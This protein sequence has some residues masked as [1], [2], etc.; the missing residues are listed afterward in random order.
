MTDT[1]AGTV[2]VLIKGGTVVDAGTAVEADVALAAGVVVGVGRLEGRVTADR[3]IDARGKIVMPGLVDG[4]FHCAG[5]SASP[6]A[7]DMYRGT[8]SAVCGGFTTVMAHVF[9]ERGQPLQEA[10]DGFAAGP[11]SAAVA[12]FGMHCGVRPERDLIRQIAGV[13]ES[14]SRS[15]KFHLDYRKTGD[16]RMFDTDLLL[17]AMEH[18]AAIGGLAIVHAEDGHVIDYLED[19]SARAGTSDAASFLAT[20]P[21]VSE[22]MAIDRVAALAELSGCAV[23]FAHITSARGASR[24][25]TLQA[26]RAGLYAETQPHYLVLTDDDLQRHGIMAKVG[27]PLRASHDLAAVWRAVASGTVE[28]LSSDH[29]AYREATKRAA[30]SNFLLEAP[31]GMPGV[32][33]VLPITYTHGVLQDRI[34]LPRMV[35]LLSEAPARRLGIHPK[36]GSFAPGADADVVIL[37]PTAAWTARAADLHSAADFTPYE[38]WTMR[39]RVDT[40]MLRGLAVVE[41]G[42]PVTGEPAGRLVRQQPVDHFRA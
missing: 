37:D 30:G 16:G 31:F 7:D 9:G 18:V 15:F 6:V 20:R 21:D 26:A 34:S 32:E 4:H 1:A 8:L 2:D 19:K 40:V 17:E 24:L 14:G 28:S 12:D 11:G 33:T 36:K 23:L 35:R 13:P 3:V 38:G 39:G 27:P 41:E 42:R 10:L 25:A 22:E 5:G 29:V